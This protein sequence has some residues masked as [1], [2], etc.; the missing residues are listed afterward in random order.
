MELVNSELVPLEE[1][2]SGE[3]EGE[4]EKERHPIDYNPKS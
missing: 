4:R 2:D 3:R 1:T